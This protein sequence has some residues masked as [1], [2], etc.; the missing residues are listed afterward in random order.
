M[1]CVFQLLLSGDETLQVTSAK[2]IAAILVH[3]PS[4]YSAPF[5]KAD[6]P[7]DMHTHRHKQS[8]YAKLY[9]LSPSLICL[10]QI[11]S[12]AFFVPF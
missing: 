12:T 6:V 9:K 11:I 10:L 4:Q 5:I 2:C 3:S 7:G 8:G 1:K